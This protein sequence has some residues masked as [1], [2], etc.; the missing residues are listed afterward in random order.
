MSKKLTFI[1]D[2]PLHGNV[3]AQEFVDALLM[4]AAFDQQ[5][6]VVF[7]G[8]GVFALLKNQN[9]KILDMKSMSETLDTFP[10]YDINDV[11]V[12]QEGLDER[13]LVLDQL[14]ASYTVLS[15]EQIAQ[16]MLTAHH[17]FSF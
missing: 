9:P 3:Q 11:V 12:E 15:R 10:L 2:K 8:D 17:V 7:V 16:Q 6:T 1:F 5:L 4:A 14:S 13:G